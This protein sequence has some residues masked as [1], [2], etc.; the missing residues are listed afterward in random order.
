[1]TTETM[2]S[3]KWVGTRSIR[4]DGLDKVTGRARFG[5]DYDLP[6]MLVG[7]VVRSPYAHATITSLD[8]G[9]AARMPGVKAI[10]TRDDFPEISSEEAMSG[11]SVVDFRDL[12]RNVMAR[13]KVLYVGHPVAAVAATSLRAAEA[14]AQAIE[15]SYEPH[16]HVLTVDEAMS[17][18]APILHP[19]LVTAGPG[20]VTDG[21]TN[22]AKRHLLSRGDLTGAFAEAD[23]VVEREF[24]TRQVHQGYIDPMPLSLTRTKTDDRVVWCSSQ[25][26]FLVR[27]QTAKV[28]GWELSRL[29]VIPAEIGGG[30]GGKARSIWSLSRFFSL[31]SRAAGSSSS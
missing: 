15:I 2:P 14:A 13:D 23:L 24:T 6:G 31:R 17:P 11:E 1:M 26:H 3:Y 18:N 5:A 7:V 4:P 21:P 10:V 9:A 20:P 8:T 27:D 29:K 25:G 28:L 30:F 12:S 16:P 19:D 22:I